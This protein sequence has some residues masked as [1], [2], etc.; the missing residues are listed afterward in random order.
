MSSQ[1]EIK[2]RDIYSK[3]YKFMADPQ[4][5]ILD[6]KKSLSKLIFQQ[7][8]N[9]KLSFHGKILKNE[10]VLGKIDL[11]NSGY[12]IYS[13]TKL[14]H[15]N[16]SFPPLRALEL[17]DIIL[18]KL[19]T[20]AST[21]SSPNPKTDIR[22]LFNPQTNPILNQ[23]LLAKS[24]ENVAKNDLEVIEIVEKSE[25]EEIVPESPKQNEAE[26][27][28][29]R[30]KQEQYEREQEAVKSQAMS[31]LSPDQNKFIN[32]LCRNFGIAKDHAIE[33]LML[34]NMD[35]TATMKFIAN[36]GLLLF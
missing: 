35:E 34:N 33:L 28:I 25:N 3:T 24:P 21:P 5:T 36:N 23:V 16:I 4:Q 32:K 14:P 12:L 31:Q 13:L 7:P 8:A 6:L 10:K 17:R 11:G 15:R 2:I 1:I 19:E 18:A 26:L 9:I 30:E 27:Q 20:E 29:L 22:A